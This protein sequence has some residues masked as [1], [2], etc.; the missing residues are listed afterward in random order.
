MDSSQAMLTKLIRMEDFLRPQNI[1]QYS[2]NVHFKWRRNPVD[3]RL[4]NTSMLA[5]HMSAF[6]NVIFF[7]LNGWNVL[8]HLL[9]GH[10][11]TQNPPIVS[12]TI[13]FSIR[14]L[15][16][17]LKRKDIIDFV[18]DLDRE[19]PQNIA[20]QLEKNMDQT[21][22]SFCQRYRFVQ[23]FSMVGFP[24]FCTLPVGVF[25]LTHEGIDVPV[26]LNEQLLGGWLPF[27]IRLNPKFYFLV[28][29]FDVICTLCGVS[30]FLSFDNLFNVMQN[31]LIMH[32]NDLSKRIDAFDPV[33]SVTNEKMCFAKLSALVQ[34][35]QLL[36]ELCRRLSNFHS[37]LY[38]S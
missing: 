4:E 1:Q 28:W 15:M 30:F 33:D 29:T 35:Q 8:E 12:I 9:F 16:L 11:N 26:S 34:R 27:G 5:F 6:W 36:N 10:P 13:Y 18:N 24:I 25:V 31:H 37:Y 7:S 3:N 19:W 20:S 23:I 2:K 17:Y 21:Y 14:G 38:L 32:L 22:L